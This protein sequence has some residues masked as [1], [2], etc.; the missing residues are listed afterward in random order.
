MPLHAICSTV[1]PAS[2]MYGAAPHWGAKDGNALAFPQ[3][4]IFSSFL[5]RLPTH[6][7][8]AWPKLETKQADTSIG[9]Y[10]DS[11]ALNR[12]RR[13]ERDKA[14]LYPCFAPSFGTAVG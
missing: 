6:P 5:A 9:R 3:Y 14:E 1:V 4:V 8:M 7:Q 13:Q 11:Y 10:P 12:L 2:Q